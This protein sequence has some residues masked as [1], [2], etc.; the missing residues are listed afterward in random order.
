MHYLTKLITSLL[1]WYT[2]EPINLYLPLIYHW[3]TVDIPLVYSW[4]PWYTLDIPLI[5]WVINTCYAETFWCSLTYSLT[6]LIL[7]FL[8]WPSPLKSKIICVS[9]SDKTLKWFLF[10]SGEKNGYLTKLFFISDHICIM[11]LSWY[12]FQLTFA[13]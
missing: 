10:F 13:I 2:L 11:I 9:T 7:L 5:P 6:D 8:E 1:P 12:N 3:Y 4:Y